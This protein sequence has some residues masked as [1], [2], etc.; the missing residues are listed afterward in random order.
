MKRD[1]EGETTSNVVYFS[2][3][4]IEK[5]PAYGMPTLFVAGVQPVEEIEK[6]LGAC[7]HIFFGANHS[8]DP[9]EEDKWI[10]WEE[11]IYCVH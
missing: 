5:T 3:I 1:Y 6:R 10:E 8:F 4:E 9:K 7:K 11:K 2:G